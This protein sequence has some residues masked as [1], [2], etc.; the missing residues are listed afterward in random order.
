MYEV[1]TIPQPLDFN[2]P[3]SLDLLELVDLVQVPYTQDMTLAAGQMTY[4]TDEGAFWIS[5]Q[6]ISRGYIRLRSNQNKIA[7]GDVIKVSYEFKCLNDLPQ[8]QLTGAFVDVLSASSVVLDNSLRFCPSLKLSDSYQL[9]EFESVIPASANGKVDRFNFVV[10]TITSP[11]SSQYSYK[12]RNIKIEIIH[13]NGDM[14][15]PLAKMLRGG[16]SVD[17]L[18]N[19]ALV[20]NAS[21]MPTSGARNP[22][23]KSG[24]YG[25]L[26]NSSG[27][28]GTLYGNGL[29]FVLP[30]RKIGAIDGEP[31]ITHIAL[32][33]GAQGGAMYIRHYD[34]ATNL[35]TSWRKLTNRATNT[36]GRP[37]NAAQGDVYYDWTIGKLIVWTGARWNDQMGNFVN[38]PTS[39]SASGTKGD[40]SADANY[41]YI[42]YNTNQWIRIAKDTW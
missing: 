25:L 29:L 22:H 42:C 12:I 28:D 5:P 19:V 17:S 27:G 40:F 9:C 37:T 31:A 36:A 8:T 18:S 39:A 3:Y 34:N 24:V 35:F 2:N 32:V 10:G 16:L 21:T 33:N 20:D 41:L 6:T 11:T 4:D 23:L 15:T 7:E 30:Y 13:Q 38:T 1:I 14:I 26:N